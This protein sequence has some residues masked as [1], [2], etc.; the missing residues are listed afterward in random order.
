MLYMS[1]HLVLATAALVALP[2][3]GDTL[4]AE[5][6]A[7]TRLALDELTHLLRV[8]LLP[9][10][11][12]R[13]LLRATVGEDLAAH[14]S[15][16]STC[17]RCATA[18][19][20]VCCLTCGREAT[21]SLE[22][23]SHAILSHLWRSP[24]PTLYAALSCHRWSYMPARCVSEFA[25]GA[26]LLMMLSRGVLH[27]IPREGALGGGRLAWKRE[28]VL[29]SISSSVVIGDGQHSLGME[30]VPF[31]LEWP[32]SVQLH[33][34]TQLERLLSQLGEFPQRLADLESEEARCRLACLQLAAREGR[35]D[36]L[37]KLMSTS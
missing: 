35:K 30:R 6:A 2:S 5:E 24:Q 1:A 22:V 19:S 11:R 27:L 9:G 15:T 7:R 4:Q 29:L 37:A 16:C 21:V 32:S 33:G 3:E 25:A 23:E 26:L 34:S 18:S 31:A 13:A 12:R 10:C 20:G 14:C 28:R 8:L 36:V 17:D